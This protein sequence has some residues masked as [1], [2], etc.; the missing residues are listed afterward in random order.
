MVRAGIR[1]WPWPIN[2]SLLEEDGAHTLMPMLEVV[3]G[4]DL[5]IDALLMAP[6][7]QRARTFFCLAWDCEAG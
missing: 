6:N 5:I 2:I 4:Y 3:V 1:A 7:P